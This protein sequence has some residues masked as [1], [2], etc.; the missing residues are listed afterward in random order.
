MGMV[1]DPNNPRAVDIAAFLEARGV[2]Q[3]LSDEITVVVGGDGF[4]LRTV[5]ERDPRDTIFLGINC[6]RLGFLLNDLPD[7]LEALPDLILS[8]RLRIRTFP[9]ILMTA[10]NTEGAVVTARGLNDV[11]LQRAGGHGCHLKIWI[12]GVVVVEHM[13]CDGIIFCTSL[14]ST[15]YSFSAGASPCHPSLNVIGVTPI[16]PHAPRLP[17]LYVPLESTVE[18][19]VINPAL[20]PVIA[21]VDGYSYGEITRV[22]IRDGHDPV[23]L[24]FFPGH[25]FTKTLVSK[26]LI[27]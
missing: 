6:G 9:R 14:G 4:M 3:R 21:V 25:H 5:R 18:A 8:D 17:P 10:E 2:L 19:Q 12:N 24:A 23:R 7:D 22:R 1:Y 26:L 16:C 13:V 27:T 15:A 20:R 11:Y